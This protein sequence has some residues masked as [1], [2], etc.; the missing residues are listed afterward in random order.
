MIERP[1]N[2]AGARNIQRLVAFLGILFILASQFLIFSIPDLTFALFP[3]YTGLAVFGVIILVLSQ[4]IPPTPFFQKL[5]NWFIFQDKAFWVMAGFLFSALAAGAM[6]S[7][8]LFTRVNYI[9]VVTI[10]GL[11]VGAYVYAFLEVPFE[12]K[13]FFEWIRKNRVEIFM[14]AVVVLF[15]A[16]VRFYQLGALPRVLDGDEGSVGLSARQTVQ[17]PLANPFALWEN[18]GALYLQAINLSLKLFGVNA[19]GLRLLP[20]IG[21]VLAIPSLYLLARWISGRRI[22]LIAVFILA[23]SHSHIHFSRIASVAYIQG[24][25]LIPLELYFLISGLEKRQSWRTA[26]S[27]IILAIHFSVYLSSQ[28]VLGVIFVFLLIAFLF[29]RN[30]FKSRIPQALVFLGGFLVTILPTVVYGLKNPGQFMYRLD[31]GGTFQTGYLTNVMEATG[32]NAAQVLTERVVHAFLSLTYYPAQDF[33][34]ST[35]PMMSMITSVLF[36]VGLGL[37]LWRIRRPEYLLLNGYFWG[38]TISIGVFAIP[39]S[40]DSY[41]ML[42]AL[43]AAVIMASLGLDQIL[44]LL[45]LD[46]KTARVAYTISVSTILASLLAFNLWTYYGEF[47]GKCLFTGDLPGRFASYLGREAIGVENEMQVYLLS[48]ETYYY[49]NHPSAFFLSNSRSINNSPDSIDQIDIV[50]GETII[51][52]PSRITELE[53]WVHA[54]PGGELHYQYDCETTI[55]LSYRLP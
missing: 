21:G 48:D 31:R 43:P 20:A 24:T 8:M 9:P 30:W 10:W 27:G 45:E 42:M 18:F 19:F 39:P 26:L 49:G 2:K 15:A 52:P 6:A 7:F 5:S 47:A 1:E 40:A 33:Y 50:S 53:E 41:R 29:Y 55:L 46:V 34:G 38:A 25:W 54:H 13:V 23:F 16:V 35:A 17:G 37:A 11:G 12:P 28:V 36:L 3:P 4:F 44:E 14:V 51:A 32:Q 22:A